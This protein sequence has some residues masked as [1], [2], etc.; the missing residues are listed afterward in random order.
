M[1]PRERRRSRIAAWFETTRRPGLVLAGLILLLYGR[2]LSRG[3]I[4]DD[5]RH[6]RLMEAFHRGERDTLD[7]YQFLVSD[8]GN[9]R[10]RLAGWY[11]WWLGDDVRYAHWRPVAEWVLYAQYLVFEDQALGYRVFGLLLYAVGVRLVLSLFRRIDVDERRCRW[12]ALIF[13]AMAG[14]AIPVVFI[15][16]HADLVALV[17]VLGSML[18]AIGFIGRG[19][20]W[21]LALAGVLYGIS[22]GAKEACLP[23]AVLPACFALL[24]GW[25][26]RRARRA[27]GATVVLLAIGLVWFGFYVRGGYGANTS[28]MLDPVNAP[29]GYLQAMPGRVL[30]LLSSFVIPLNPFVFYFRPRGMPWLYVYCVVGA[31]ALL[32]LARTLWIHHRRERGVAVM[33]LWIAP[34]LPL[35]A[36]T[37]PDDRVMVLPGVGFAFLVG[38]WMT[39]R[40]ADGPS[41]LRKLPLAVFVVLHGLAAIG[42]GE[43]LRFVERDNRDFLATA[44]RT[45]GRDPEACFF[46]LND[47]RDWQ[48]LFIQ[49]RAE[50]IAGRR[51]IR[52][53]FLS[54]AEDPVVSRVGEYTLRIRDDGDGLFTSFWG[55]MG[56]SRDRPKREGQ[57]F[58]AGEYVGR[59]VEVS[60]GVVRE[61]ELRFD[62]PLD[63]KRY[64]FFRCTRFGEPEPWVPPRT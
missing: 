13:A 32:L 12:S 49:L 24:D 29:L 30:T 55:A 56:T 40:G 26:D 4:L 45:E 51:D 11:P 62:R 38:V 15:S 34:F 3:F 58:D 60:D 1:N 53:A 37:V 36:C 28:V 8:A 63:S 5:H 31:V 35:L 48:V 19:R 10:E 21:R 17:L 9:R 57:R 41:G 59:I 2:S 64:H 14:H 20:W 39:R 25:R 18:A 50:G 6:L 22:L 52:A 46:F 27:L 61:V 42:V 23:A 54:D 43:C 44:M 7:L 16:A 33:A 47:T